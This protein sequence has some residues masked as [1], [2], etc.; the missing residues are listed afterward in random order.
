[1]PQ[2]GPHLLGLPRTRVRGFSICGP[3]SEYLRYLASRVGYMHVLRSE[4]SQWETI[5]LPNE[6]SN[7]SL[8]KLV[9]VSSTTIKMGHH[10][11]RA[12]HFSSSFNHQHG[13]QG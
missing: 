1:M 8:T 9:P 6:S 3:L 12:R 4:D 7:V 2:L 5:D 13:S 11:L 10:H